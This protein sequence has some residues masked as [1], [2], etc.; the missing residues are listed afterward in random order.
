MG[1]SLSLSHIH[2]CSNRTPKAFTVT[3]GQLKPACQ[4]RSNITEGGRR[5]GAKPEHYSQRGSENEAAPGHTVMPNWL[6]LLSSLL[7][8]CY[9]K[10]P[11]TGLPETHDT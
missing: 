4:D 7:T 9:S 8:D 5:F 1:S 6:E 10:Q 2:T 11:L 3:Q